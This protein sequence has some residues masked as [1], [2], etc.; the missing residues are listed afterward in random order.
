[1]QEDERVLKLRQE[2]E[3]KTI[4][5]TFLA[6]NVVGKSKEVITAEDTNSKKAEDLLNQAVAQMETKHPFEALH[7][8]GVLKCEFPD[9][10]LAKDA[11]RQ[12]QV[13]AGASVGT[14]LKGGVTLEKLVE[15]CVDRCQKVCPKCGGMGSIPC[16]TCQGQGKV[17]VTCPICNGAGRTACLACQG[18]GKIMGTAIG[19]FVRCPACMGKGSFPCAE[20]KGAKNV[21][22]I[23]PTC[24]GAKTLFCDA[25]GGTGQRSS[26]FMNK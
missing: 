18:T 26:V 11:A 13:I 12:A 4:V 24:N 6:Q 15:A 20:C 14:A 7:A 10:A 1:M 9:T 23:C 19:T 17:Q 2:K 3:G 21:S 25:C 5:R 16:A 8:L 22:Q